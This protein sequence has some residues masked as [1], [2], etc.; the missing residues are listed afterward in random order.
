MIGQ[1]ISHYK[2]TAKLGEGGMGEVYLAVDSKLDRKVA[3][4]FLPRQ[5]SSQP[6]AKAR[7]LQE[8]RAASAL[9]HPNICTI[10]DLQ[11]VD[12]QMFIVMEYV[13][14]QTLRDRTQP[15]TLKQV[16]E[17]GIQVADGLA[18]AHEKGIVHRDIKTENLMMRKDGIVQIMDFGL[19]KLRGASRLTK[20]GSTVGTVGYM[21][22]EQVQG[23]ET[24]HRTDLFSVGV[25]LYE[26]IAGQ[27]PFK[28]AH[29]TAIMY[30]ILNVDPQPLSA[31]R[32]DIEPELDRLIL[33]CL[34]KNP[35]ERCQ[36]AR[37]IS[38]DLRRFKID[39]GRKHQSR[40]STVRPSL[41]VREGLA[42]SGATITSGGGVGRFKWFAIVAAVAAVVTA[43]AF[44]FFWQRSPV[45][46][47]VHALRFTIAAPPGMSLS[48]PGG[49]KIALSP[50]G[51][52]LVFVAADSTGTSHLWLRP[53]NA[54]TAER[55][56][57]TDGG[58]YPFWAPDSRQIGF[59]ATG[60]LKKIDVTGG[61]PLTLCDAPAGRGGTW[62]REG[63]IVF[64]PNWL[65]GLS[66]V[67]ASGGI[68]VAT[69]RT[70]SLQNQWTHR[71]PHFLP[72]GNRFLYL[73]RTGSVTIDS[74][75]WLWVGSLDGSVNRALMRSVSNAGY[76]NGHIIFL[77]ERTLMAQRFDAGK[78]EPV[79]DPA[80]VA[81]G[82]FF[83]ADYSNADFSVA[84]NGT[85]AYQAGD[86]GAGYHLIWFDR[87]GRRT[88][89]IGEPGRYRNCMLSPDGRFLAVDL[90][91]DVSA[92]NSDV[93]VYDLNRDVKT[94]LTFAPGGDDYPVWSP[95]GSH[96]YF[97]S[98]RGGSKRDL[99]CKPSSGA[100]EE[101][102]LLTSDRDKYPTDCAPDGRHLVFLAPQTRGTGDDLW[103]LPLAE[104]GAKAASDPIPFQQTAFSEDDARFSPDGRWLA[105]YSDETGRGEVYVRPL[106]GAGGKW[107]ISTEAGDY[108]CWRHDGRELFYL[109]EKNMLMVV[110]VN[111][112]GSSFEAGRPRPLFQLMNPIPASTISPYDVTADG[113]R[114]VIITGD[115][116]QTSTINVVLNWNAEL[117]TK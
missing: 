94:R 68:P 110:N 9:N 29:E 31:I 51:Q 87:S 63:V 60:K 40:V 32:D 72:D 10:Y 98:S 111:G 84:E 78:A 99:Y 24:D 112:T 77:R 27:L 18:A 61:P 82:V 95:D 1:T 101:Q 49:G 17:I 22:P 62:N 54:L 55:L 39:S 93:S 80:P 7:F 105:Y 67:S 48:G 65:G 20:E 73:V 59:F 83:N 5:M 81:E 106:A 19:A 69:T 104:G 26:L 6:D 42:A 45:S 4:K 43:S 14:G 56:S 13:E 3:L 37:E 88:D 50:D 44:L 53:L 23:L 114:F 25:V 66:R 35:N 115:A 46:S 97:S 16:V 100:G 21:S 57:G 38:R 89:T 47:V 109:S 74:N 107:Q 33:D 70:D 8:A 92:N 117:R 116:G 41:S 2:I 34:Q 79:G 15:F 12:S 102:L 90:T 96:I 103:V 64:A 113:Q 36:S 52:R 71:W 76:A 58:F 28:G 30:E 86:G 91:A 108:P 75:S 11:E 85:L